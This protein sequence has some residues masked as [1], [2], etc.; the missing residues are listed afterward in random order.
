LVLV[1]VF[2]A[3]S[4]FG[5][6]LGRLRQARRWSVMY[7][8]RADPNG[9]SSSELRGRARMGSPVAHGFDVVLPNAPNGTSLLGQ[10]HLRAYVAAIGRAIDL[11]ARARVCQFG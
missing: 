8:P 1:F 3:I 6:A 11:A 10:G 5:I 9:S 4:P 2:A 7:Q